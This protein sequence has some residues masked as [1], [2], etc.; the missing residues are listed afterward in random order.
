M[1][2]CAA[3]VCQAWTI[4]QGQ[5]G[6]ATIAVDGTSIYWASETA[7]QVLKSAKDGTSVF[8]LSSSAGSSPF[9][10]AID[11]A[12][13]YWSEDSADTPVWRCPK[14]GCDGGG[15]AITPATLQNTGA[16]AVAGKEVFVAE[17]EV[18][19]V[20]RTAA[21]DG[22]ALA[23]VATNLDHT[24]GVA[25][26]DASVF[27]STS[28]IV[29]RVAATAPGTTSDTG[30]AGPYTTLFSAASNAIGLIVAADGNLYWAEN[31]EP[32]G[33][34]KSIPKAGAPV[35]KVYSSTETRPLSIAVDDTTVYWTAQGPNSSTDPNTWI[36]VD[37]YVAACP[38]AGCPA[39]GPVKIAT[40]LHNPAGIAVDATAI[41]VTIF[42]NVG[43]SGQ[44][45][46]GSIM[47]AMK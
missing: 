12:N 42:G 7:G 15:I 40:G 35:P 27:F 47:K 8:L 21:P 32:G 11:D 18:G 46:E 10:L 3:G 28:S 9:T 13:V 38:K 26:D 4:V 14:T 39:S 36:Y 43:S 41:Y 44:N 29:G 19:A 45:N 34:V 22:G 37:G 2:G 20:G 30:D 16:I 31:N 23:F 6:T 1:G 33:A 24:Y 5:P 25:A 17:Y